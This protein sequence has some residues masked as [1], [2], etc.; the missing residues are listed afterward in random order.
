MGLEGVELVMAVEDEFEISIS[1]FHA[2]NLVT[3]GDLIEFV[4]AAVNGFDLSRER[5]EW[6]RI[7]EEMERV[8]GR[9]IA[10]LPRSTMIVD[11]LDPD[12][13]V[14]QW[15]ELAGVPPPELP[16]FWRSVLKGVLV[17]VFVI[18]FVALGV[19]QGILMLALFLVLVCWL[20]LH[21]AFARFRTVPDRDRTLASLVWWREPKSDEDTSWEA[22]A[23]KVRDIVGRELA[24]E[25]MD[26]FTND[27]RFIKDLG[28][29]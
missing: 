18:P 7:E 12:K 16:P 29:D 22:I 19:S 2:G 17:V 21:L 26:R 24:I 20:A 8:T 3:I 15:S 28:V 9:S 13:E 25:N 5:E 1:D 4:H 23:E 27:A 6:S 11:L 14:E 10:E